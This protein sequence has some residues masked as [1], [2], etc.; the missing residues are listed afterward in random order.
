MYCG[1]GTNGR[2]KSNLQPSFGFPSAMNFS[3]M[4]CF[5]WISSRLRAVAFDGSQP[6]PC[7]DPGSLCGTWTGRKMYEDFTNKGHDLGCLWNVWE[8]SLASFTQ[9][10]AR[11][12]HC[13][14]SSTFPSLVLIPSKLAGGMGWVMALQPFP[15]GSLD[16][17]SL[18]LGKV[19]WGTCQS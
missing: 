12:L 4:F 2:S 17:T 8:G 18:F 13:L 6:V 14:I 7:S 3:W 1:E 16:I 5:T 9:S 10:S 11:A 19:G 15:A